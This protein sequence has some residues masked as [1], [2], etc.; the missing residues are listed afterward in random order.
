M[1]IYIYMI[2][3]TEYISQNF[4]IPLL[5]F[6]EGPGQRFVRSARL[7]RVYGRCGSGLTHGMAD[8]STGWQVQGWFLW[9]FNGAPGGFHVLMLLETLSF[10]GLVQCNS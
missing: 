2:Y 3:F 9:G 7:V 1:Y 10:L 6:E 4:W 8:P 5:V